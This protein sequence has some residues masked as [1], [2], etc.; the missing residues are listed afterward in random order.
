MCPLAERSAQHR[1][2]DALGEEPRRKLH[3][4]QVEKLIPVKLQLS[5][6]HA[7]VQCQMH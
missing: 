6:L 1:L 5:K 2:R 7:L 3:V 4:A